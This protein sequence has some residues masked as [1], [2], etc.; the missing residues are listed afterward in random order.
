MQ[1]T[2]SKQ[3]VDVKAIVAK[4]R[5]SVKNVKATIEKVAEI[6]DTFKILPGFSK[7]EFNGVI[8]RNVKTKNII[9]MKT[10]RTK[11]QIHDDA[12]KS[13]NLSK[14]E[15]KAL[16]PAEPVKAKTVKPKKET[17]KKEKPAPANNEE[18][19]EYAKKLTR[20]QIKK[21]DFK[22]HKKI[23]LLHLKGDSNK[24]IHD[25][26]NAPIPTIARDIW[27]YKTGKTALAL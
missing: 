15:I 10:G 9:S 1:T 27:R 8:L 23:Y 25:L 3:P 14:D 5:N 18:A 26:L 17:V 13:H 20:D 2:T 21:M 11:Y 4:A 19:V 6:K 16:F 22:Q 12:G 7:F 24:E